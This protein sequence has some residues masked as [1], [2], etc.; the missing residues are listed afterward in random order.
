MA[1]GVGAGLLVVAVVAVRPVAP[2][3]LPLRLLTQPAVVWVGIVSYGIYLWHLPVR[4]LLRLRLFSE[5]VSG[6]IGGAI[7]RWLAVVIGVLGCAAA[8]WYLL[9]RPAQRSLCPRRGGR[10]RVRGRL[11]ETSEGVHST[12]VALNSVG[13]AVDHLA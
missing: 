7:A 6:G 11:P 10:R 5:H 1:M 13:V 2:G 4:D 9:E 12:S 3:P 8:S